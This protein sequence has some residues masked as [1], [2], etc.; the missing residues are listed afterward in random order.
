MLAMVAV[1]L[2]KMYHSPHVIRMLDHK[3]LS[4]FI[5]DTS[6][7]KESPSVRVISPPTPAIPRVATGDYFAV[8]RRRKDN[9]APPLSPVWNRT[10]SSPTANLVSTS[11]SSLSSRGSW[12]SLFNTGSMRQLMTG[13][14]QETTREIPYP[15]SSSGPE[16]EIVAT[17]VP[18]VRKHI[19]SASGM[20]S[21]TSRRKGRATDLN[22]DVSAVTSSKRISV[23]FA[24][25]LAQNSQGQHPT[26]SQVVSAR[27]SLST[28]T[29]VVNDYQDTLHQEQYV[30]MMISSPIECGSHL[31][32]P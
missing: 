2:L 32:E 12:S 15:V 25:G 26:F 9:R 4:T 8:V 20:D 24:P 1:I 21:P 23:A 27:T 13:T 18:G 3:M 6:S 14:Q 7:D 16:N 31:A 22:M 29:L 28:K 5:A 10:A 19:P 17:P 11:L 30:F